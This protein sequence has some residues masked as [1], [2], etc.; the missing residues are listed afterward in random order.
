MR[1]E[2]PARRIF[3]FLFTFAYLRGNRSNKQTRLTCLAKFQC[4]ARAKFSQIF[5]LLYFPPL[6]NSSVKPNCRIA[7]SRA[8]EIFARKS[9]IFCV[10]DEN[11]IRSCD[12]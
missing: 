8:A 11:I 12:N 9:K 3:V 5:P 6:R 4:R 7:G 2:E 10:P 1:D